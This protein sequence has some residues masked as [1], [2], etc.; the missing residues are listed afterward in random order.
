MLLQNI[1]TADKKRVAKNFDVMASRKVEEVTY[2][3]DSHSTSECMLDY[4]PR[5]ER[6]MFTELLE[7][8]GNSL[9]YSVAEKFS[10]APY[11]HRRGWPDLTI[12]KGNELRFIEVKAPGDRVHKSQ[13][14]I[15]ANFAKPL[16]LD[17]WLTEVRDAET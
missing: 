1:L 16:G 17:F 13:R 9:I 4:C 2:G 11:D 7:V 8:A 14:E 12:L 10:E 3:G 5:L 15:I 6:C